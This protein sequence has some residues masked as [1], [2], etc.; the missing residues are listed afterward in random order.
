M[1][2]IVSIKADDTFMGKIFTD[3]IW[4][5]VNYLI[6]NFSLK[7]SG[8]ATFSIALSYDSKLMTQTRVKN[9]KSKVLNLTDFLKIYLSA[10]FHSVNTSNR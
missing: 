10:Y 7:A 9:E 5:K 1:I 3:A 8:D 2:N 6:S 4:S